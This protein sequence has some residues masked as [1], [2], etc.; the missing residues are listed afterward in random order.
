M[1][2]QTP[3]LCHNSLFSLLYSFILIIL[4]SSR[5]AWAQDSSENT[6]YSRSWTPEE[7]HDIGTAASA[8]QLEYYIRQ[9]V[10]LG[11]VTPYRIPF[12]TPEALAQLD[13]GLKLSLKKYQ[14]IV[15]D[16]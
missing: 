7:L 10:V 5:F 1:N 2:Q 4:L 8:E 16:A 6:N 15:V 13:V 3:R 9:L 12:R 14:M 11:H